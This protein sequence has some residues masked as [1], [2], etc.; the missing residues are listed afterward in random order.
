MSSVFLNFMFIYRSRLSA[1]SLKKNIYAHLIIKKMYNYIQI[2]PTNKV[3]V[4]L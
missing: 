1:I 3:M 2:K 4:D